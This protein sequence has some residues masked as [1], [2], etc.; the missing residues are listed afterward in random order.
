MSSPSLSNQEIAHILYQIGEY[1][2]LQEVAFKPQAYERATRAIEAM[3]TPVGEIYEKGGQKALGEIP[4]VGESIAEKI[5]E[6]I[7]TGRLKYFEQLKK[8]LPMDVEALSAIE[9]VGPK[10]I[11]QFWQK[12]KIKNVADLEKAAKAGRLRKLFRMSEKLEQ[13][14]LRSIAFH[15]EHGSRFF[16]GAVLPLVRGIE[17]RIQKLQWTQ[18]AVVAGSIR[19]RKET[20]GDCDIL[21]T[22]DNPARVMDY[23][24]KMPEVSEVLAHGDTKSMVR[25]HNGLELDLRVVPEASFGAALQYF[26]GNKDHNVALRKIAISKNLTLNEYGLFEIAE[27]RRIY[28]AKWRGK[29]RTTQ[30]GKQIAGRTEE[31]IYEKLGLAYIEPE[32]REMAGEIEAAQ[33]GKLPYL[34]GYGDL[35]G[36]LQTQ[37]NWTDGVNSIEE[38]AQA[39]KN[40]GLSYIAITDHSK[41]LAMTGGLDEKKI[42]KQ[43]AEIDRVNKKL[44]GIRI[45]KGSE[46]DILK[47]GSLDLPDAILAQLDV[48]GASVHS[49]FEMPRAETTLRIVRAMEN[50]HVDILFHPTGRVVNKRKPY[51]V[52]METLCKAAKKTGTVLEAN[53]SGRLDLKDEH[54]KM[55]RDTGVKIAI[56]SDA[57]ATTQFSMLE[58][59]IA[60]ARRGWAE[61]KDVINARPLEK[62]LAMLKNKR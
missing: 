11:K 4:G 44:K 45:L 48:V 41:R 49:Y 18:K 61:K 31:E 60:Q 10:H 40:A 9:G 53:A 20:I 17:A 33:S 50:P 52:D 38:M 32:M 22:S 8:K 3:E 59:G 27:Q 23:F 15:K 57:H 19:R 29:R 30:K 55:A 51:E 62:M 6:L 46:V 54:I 13:K 14:I 43:W 28:P 16:I 21:A 36:D 58:Y 12:L 25:L 34:I 1:L 39:A 42:K 37:T 47:D 5:E 35:Q 26:T 7:K 24:V 56:N 2:E